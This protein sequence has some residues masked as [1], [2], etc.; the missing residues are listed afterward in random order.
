MQPIIPVC[1]GDHFEFCINLYSLRG[2]VDIESI[3][4]E[5]PALYMMP[6]DNTLTYNRD[7]FIGNISDRTLKIFCD[8]GRVCELED[9]E[10][11][12][13]ENKYFDKNFGEP[14]YCA[15]I[16]EYKHLQK[17]FEIKNIMFSGVDIFVAKVYLIAK[18]EG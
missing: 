9:S 2:L 3:E 18:R 7:Y 1:V 4:W 6:S 5:E 12:W 11:E 13:Y 15:D 16:V 17:C 8:L 10:V 14:S